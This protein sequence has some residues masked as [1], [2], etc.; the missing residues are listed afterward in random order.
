MLDL[1]RIS[2]FLQVT[3]AAITTAA[4]TT[5]LVEKMDLAYF[6]RNCRGFDSG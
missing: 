2:V 4:A 5:E 6:L 3:T 1:A